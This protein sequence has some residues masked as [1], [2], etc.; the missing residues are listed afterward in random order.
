MAPG[1][2][3]CAPSARSP[4]PTP[5]NSAAPG[6]VLHGS[7]RLKQAGVHH[8]PDFAEKADRAWLSDG[9]SLFIAVLF[10]G[11]GQLLLLGILGEYVGRIYGEVKCRPLYCVKERLGFTSISR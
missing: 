9:V 6:P 10:A 4:A 5:G 7:P 2:G 11:G 1:S 3:P 8:L